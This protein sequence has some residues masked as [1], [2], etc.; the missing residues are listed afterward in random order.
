MASPAHISTLPPPARVDDAHVLTPTHSI[1]PLRHSSPQAE[2]DLERQRIPSHNTRPTRLYVGRLAN[3]KNSPQVWAGPS[4]SEL[5]DSTTSA[6]KAVSHFG[7]WIFGSGNSSINWGALRCNGSPRLSALPYLSQQEMNLRITRHRTSIGL[8]A[9]PLDSADSRANSSIFPQFKLIPCE[10]FRARRRDLSE[11][12]LVN[13]GC[14]RRGTVTTTTRKQSGRMSKW[15][16]LADGEA[17]AVVL[18]RR[19]MYTRR[20]KRTRS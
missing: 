6:R 19:P 17:E 14:Q 3:G 18:P 13:R 5:E 1:K 10:T 12:W 4:H 9:V 7:N 8:S 11:K 15:P 20:T 2:Q 16:G